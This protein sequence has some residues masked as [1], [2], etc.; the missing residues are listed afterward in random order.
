MDYVE[1]LDLLDFLGLT[2]NLF[3]PYKDLEHRFEKQFYIQ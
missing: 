2:I 3:L 1:N